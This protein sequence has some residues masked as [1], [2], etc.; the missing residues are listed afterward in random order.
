MKE[1]ILKYIRHKPILRKILSSLYI[2]YIKFL[3]FFR[4]KSF[5]KK[6]LVDPQKIVYISWK[7]YNIF[8]E[9]WK[10]L[11]WNRDLNTELFE[12][13]PI[14][15]WLKERFIE[16]KER[17]KT[18]YFSRFLKEIQSWKLM[19]NCANENEL[20]E[21]CK[22]LDS[23][24]ESIKRNWVVRQKSDI[25]W[26]FDQI[27]INIWRKWALLFNDWAHRLAIA[28]LLWINKIPVRIIWRHKNRWKLITYLHSVLPNQVSYQSLWHP[29]LDTNF[30]IDHDCY[31]RFSLIK[32]YIPNKPIWKSLDIGWNIW[33]FTRKLEELWYKAHIIEHESFY[34]WVLNKFKELIGYNY[35]VIEKDM[36][37]RHWIHE[38]SYQ[39][40]LALN[41]FHHFIKT[42]E[43]HEKLVT[44]LGNLQMKM[45]IFES[46]DPSETQMHWAYKNY[47]PEEFI[48]FIIKHTTLTKYEEIWTMSN[49]WR[50]LYCIS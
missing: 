47:T 44:L 50:K 4:K 30:I 12:N 1:I 22:W 29:D 40:V 11:W 43:F 28:K 17:K 34:I 7:Y 13:T 9:E 2:Q 33:F 24:Y 6:Y 27:T 25:T 20:L 42:E 38:N 19:R 39:L 35:K 48:S 23:L 49:D 36:F 31:E 14:Y 10:V 5:E 32:N 26:E 46:H 18:S 3:N 41:I 16:K 15:Q 21:R 45:M 8:K 37:R